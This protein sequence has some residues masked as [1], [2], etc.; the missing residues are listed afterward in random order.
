MRIDIETNNQAYALQVDNYLDGVIRPA[1]A[2]GLNAAAD[3]KKE[4][5]LE[6]AGRDFDRPNP[7]P[8]SC[9]DVL[10]ARVEDSCEL[11]A[12][13]SISPL[14]LPTWIFRS[15]AVFIVPSTD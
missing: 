10:P 14:R 6:A 12:V 13:V 3:L 11:S 2:I 5:L 4:D 7:F 15:M 8:L 9:F 1:I